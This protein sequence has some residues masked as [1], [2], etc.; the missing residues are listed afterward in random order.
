MR[1]DVR[2][3]DARIIEIVEIIGHGDVKLA[4][5][6]QAIYKMAADEASSAGYQDSSHG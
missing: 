6:H 3:L 5:G 2:A 1:L 4:I